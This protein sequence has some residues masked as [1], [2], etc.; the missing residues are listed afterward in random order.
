M[1]VTGSPRWLVVARAASSRPRAR[2]P[3][4]A[5]RAS[6]RALGMFIA[7]AAPPPSAH[8]LNEPM[9]NGVHNHCLVSRS[10][11]AAAPR[12]TTLLTPHGSSHP[13]SSWPWSGLCTGSVRLARCALLL[14]LMIKNRC[15]ASCGPVLPGTHTGYPSAYPL[16]CSDGALLALYF[17]CLV[18]D[19][20][21]RCRHTGKSQL[22]G[23]RSVQLAMS[24][25]VQ[26]AQVRC[27]VLL[28][29]FAP[30][31]L[32]TCGYTPCCVCVPCM[33][34][35]TACSR[36]VAYDFQLLARGC[37]CLAHKLG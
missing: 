18:T 33:L 32:L 16:T 24:K 17:A 5:G 29:A 23:N 27:R 2:A 28:G 6:R 15:N 25:A 30:A 12:P 19:S 26:K 35:V 13:H 9:R 3:M 10:G 21:L 37:T 20:A 1:G 8:K 34:L 7:H 14:G 22:E 11:S 4:R 31:C 36:Q